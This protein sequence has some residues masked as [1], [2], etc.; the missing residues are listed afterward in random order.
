M[1]MMTRNDRMSRALA[2]V[3][4]AIAFGGCNK[5]AGTVFVTVDAVPALTM[6]AKLHGSATVGTTT[7]TFDVPLTKPTIP[8]DVTFAIVVPVNLGSSLSLSLSAIDASGKTVATANGQ[9]SVSGG[10]RNDVSI[11]FGGNGPS[12]AGVSGDMSMGDMATPSDLSADMAKPPVLLPRLIAPQSTARVTTGRPTLRWVLPSGV[13]NP[14]VDLCSTRDCST[15]IATPTIAASGDHANLGNDLPKGPV[16]WRV[17][18][19]GPSGAVTSNTWEFW[20][21][22][23]GT[24]TDGAW[25]HIFDFDGDGYADVAILGSN[26]IYVYHGAAGGLAATPTPILSPLGVAETLSQSVISAGDVDGD[27]FADLAVTATN[28]ATGAGGHIYIFRGGAQGIATTPSWT[29]APSTTDLL[30]NLFA[31]DFD[32]DGYADLGIVM[33]TQTDDGGINNFFHLAIWPGG[34]SGVSGSPTVTANDPGVGAAVTT[35]DING[36]G[37]SDLLVGNAVRDR[38]A[39]WLGGPAGIQAA[40]VNAIPNPDAGH[41]FFGNQVLLGDVTGRGYC[42]AIIAAYGYNSFVGR[43]YY[44]DF[45]GGLSGPLLHIDGTDPM[46]IGEFGASLTEPG[47]IDGDGIMDFVVGASGAENKAYLITGTSNAG[48]LAVKAPI[49]TSIAMA[50]IG[51][52]G[53]G[54]GDVDHDGFDD[55]GLGT[56]NTG[57]G[58]GAVIVYYGTNGTFPGR[59][60]PFNGS[61]T[62]GQ[63]GSAITLLAPSLRRR[64]VHGRAL[65]GFIE[66]SQVRLIR[67]SRRLPRMR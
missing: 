20:V 66:R 50:N 62:N 47:D 17:R 52:I 11:H 34:P 59:V 16:F 27:G 2:L 7:R 46:N 33:D 26:N 18:A 31:G 65:V 54:F 60:V 63:F 15:L 3:V 56:V 36:D 45:S 37:Y 51:Q 12:D 42:S 21:T 25:D 32:R 35:G 40:E 39:F 14:Q 4:A 8:P 58:A 30:G 5:G 19:Q 41:N 55:F 1:M 29:L 64:P 24:N 22:V 9:A 61:N 10:K 6:L 13:T 28:T 43:I 23:R 57:N 49:T 67:R 38:A 44:Y 48:N 53:G